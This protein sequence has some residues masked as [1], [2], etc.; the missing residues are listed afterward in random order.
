MDPH[1]RRFRGLSFLDD[2]TRERLALVVGRSLS[3]LRLAR[4]LDHLAKLR[5]LPLMVVSDNGTE[6]TSRAILAWQEERGVEWHDIAPSTPAQNAFVESLNGRFRDERLNEHS[7]QGLR[8]AQRIIEA[9]RADDH[10]RR[11]HASLGGLTPDE[12]ATWS[13]Q[14]RN[15]NRVWL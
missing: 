10:T 15:Q 7:F 6:R 5:G 1:G 12:F 8:M 3:V 14:D 9:W 13:R 2:F 11:P 4:E